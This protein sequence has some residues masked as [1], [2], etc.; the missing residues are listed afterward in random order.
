M[1]TKTMTREEW[2]NEMV[3]KLEPLFAE[4]GYKFPAKLRVS[5]GWP[6]GRAL[7]S[8][9]AIGQCWSPLASKDATTEIFISP[10]IEEPSRAA[11]ILAHE[12]VHAAVGNEH[13]HKAPFRKCAV[14]IGLEGKMTATVAGKELTKRLNALCKEIGKYPHAQLDALRKPVQTQ[15]T[16][17]I[18]LECPGCGYVCRTTQKWIEQGTPTC[19]CGEEMAT[20]LPSAR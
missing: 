10:C 20:A 12:L 16:R 17:M 3:V 4:H 8:K 13:G 18:K 7:G 14:A 1:K 15:T 19:C 2:L 5:C 6:A 11:D 9:R